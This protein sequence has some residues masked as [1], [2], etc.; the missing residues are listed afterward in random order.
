MTPRSRRLGNLPDIPLFE[1]DEGQQRLAE[2][3]LDPAAADFAGALARD[4]VAIVDLGE[5]FAAL[6]DQAVAQTDPYFD[7]GAERV[8]DAWRRSPAIRALAA[9]AEIRRLLQAAYGRRPF[10]FQTLNFLRGTEQHLHADT[11]HFSSAPERFMCGVW[12]ALEDVAEEAGPVVYRPGSHRLP[13]LTMRDVGFNGDVPTS[14]DYERLYATSF[15]KRPELAPFP[16]RLA[17]IRKGQAFVWAANLA[18]GGSPILDPRATRRSL[19][20]H[21]YFE[22][23]AYFTPM[24]SNPDRDELHL[25]LPVNIV[26]GGWEWP[27]RKGR[28]LAVPFKRVLGEMI[29]RALNRPQVL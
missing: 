3:G 9:N 18:H 28:R 13:V 19:V 7:A 20:V 23:C 10:P 26:T 11:M 15:A 16:T 25:R 4:G 5:A 22:D 14:D 17:T 29:E 2:G 1:S 8:Q 12:I 27:S 21:F 24:W 6:C